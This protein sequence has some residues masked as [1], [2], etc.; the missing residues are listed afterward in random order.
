MPSIYLWRRLRSYYFDLYYAELDGEPSFPPF[1][2]DLKLTLAQRRR[3]AKSLD[4]AMIAVI[5]SDEEARANSCL[6]HEEL[7]GTQD[8][9]VDT[10]KKISKSLTTLLTIESQESD[11]VEEDSRLQIMDN[12]NLTPAEKTMRIL[13]ITR[14][15]IEHKKTSTTD[16]T[17]SNADISESSIDVDQKFSFISVTKESIGPRTVATQV[18]FPAGLKNDAEQHSGKCVCCEE[19]KCSVDNDEDSDEED[20]KPMSTAIVKS[21]TI[22][23]DKKGNN[24]DA[25]SSRKEKPSNCCNEN[26]KTNGEKKNAEGISLKDKIAPSG[27][28]TSFAYR[29]TDL[30]PVPCLQA[31]IERDGIAWDH[32]K[33]INFVS[34]IDK[35]LSDELKFFKLE[36]NYLDSQKSDGRPTSVSKNPFEDTNVEVGSSDKVTA[37]TLSQDKKKFRCESSQ[38]TRKILPERENGTQSNF[39]PLQFSLIEKKGFSLPTSASFGAGSEMLT[40]NASCVFDE[41]P[42]SGIQ[43]IDSMTV[44]TNSLVRLDQDVNSDSF[45]Q[46]SFQQ[47][48]NMFNDLRA[49]SDRFQYG[50]HSTSFGTARA[51]DDYS[52]FYEMDKLSGTQNYAMTRTRPYDS[53]QLSRSRIVTAESEITTFDF[54][55][56]RSTSQT[57]NFR[58]GHRDNWDFGQEVSAENEINCNHSTYGS[59]KSRDLS[60]APRDFYDHEKKRIISNSK[61]QVSSLTFN[62]S[63][64][65]PTRVSNQQTFPSQSGTAMNDTILN[66]EKF[67]KTSQTSN[68]GSVGFCSNLDPERSVIIEKSTITSVP[69][70]KLPSKECDRKDYKDRRSWASSS[71]SLRS[72]KSKTSSEKWEDRSL[73]ALKAYNEKT[74]YKYKRDMDARKSRDVTNVPSLLSRREENELLDRWT[75]SRLSSQESGPSCF[76]H[77]DLDPLSLSASIY[78]SNVNQALYVPSAP[79]LETPEKELIFNIENAYARFA[80]SKPAGPVASAAFHQSAAVKEFFDLYSGGGRLT[81]DSQRLRVGDEMKTRKQHSKYSKF[82]RETNESD[83]TSRSCKRIEGSQKGRD[84]ERTLAMENITRQEFEVYFLERQA[85]ER[86][87]SSKNV[88]ITTIKSFSRKRGDDDA[89]V[90]SSETLTPDDSTSPMIEVLENSEDIPCRID[91]N[92]FYREMR[93]KKKNNLPDNVR[94]VMENIDWSFRRMYC[95][96]SRSPQH[97]G[98]SEITLSTDHRLEH[99]NIVHKTTENL[100]QGAF[101]NSDNS[102]RGFRLGELG[103]EYYPIFNDAAIAMGEIVRAAGLRGYRDEFTSQPATEIE[104]PEID[105]GNFYGALDL[106]VKLPRSLSSRFSRCGALDEKTKASNSKQLGSMVVNPQNKIA[107]TGGRE[108]FI[109]QEE[110][111]TLLRRLIAPLDPRSTTVPEQLTEP[112][113]TREEEEDPSGDLPSRENSDLEDYSKF[114]FKS[115]PT[116]KRSPIS[117]RCQNPERSLH[118]GQKTKRSCER[119]KIALR[120]VI[121]Q[122]SSS[123]QGLKELDLASCRRI[124]DHFSTGG[125]EMRSAIVKVLEKFPHCETFVRTGDSSSLL[126]VILDERL[127]RSLGGS[128]FIAGLEMLSVLNLMTTTPSKIVNPDENSGGAEETPS[129][130]IEY[131]SREQNDRCEGKSVPERTISQS[132]TSRVIDSVFVKAM[133]ESQSSRTEVKKFGYKSSDTMESKKFSAMN[134]EDSNTLE[135][136]NSM[137]AELEMNAHPIGHESFMDAG[138]ITPDLLLGDIE[139]AESLIKKMKSVFERFVAEDKKS[140]DRVPKEEEEA[141]EEKTEISS[142]TNFDFLL[143]GE[144]KKLHRLVEVIANY[145]TV[146]EYSL[147][148]VSS[149]ETTDSPSAIKSSY[150]V[151]SFDVQRRELITGCEREKPDSFQNAAKDREKSNRDD[152]Q[153][154]QTPLSKPGSS[155]STENPMDRI[156]SWDEMIP[157]STKRELAK[158]RQKS[159]ATKRVVAVS[160]P[161]RRIV[162]V[163]KLVN[164]NDSD[165]FSARFVPQ[166]GRGLSSGYLMDSDSDGNFTISRPPTPAS[167]KSETSQTLYFDRNEESDVPSKHSAKTSEVIA[168]SETER[169][170]RCSLPNVP[171]KETSPS[172]SSPN[173][174]NNFKNSESEL[175]IAKDKID[176]DVKSLENSQRSLEKSSE[177]SLDYDDDKQLHVLSAEILLTDNALKNISPIDAIRIV[178]ELTTE[179]QQILFNQF[180]GV[181]CLTDGLPAA[182]KNGNSIT[183]SDNAKIDSLTNIQGTSYCDSVEDVNDLNRMKESCEQNVEGIM[184]VFFEELIAQ[185]K[186][187]DRISENSEDTLLEQLQRKS[188]VSLKHVATGTEFTAEVLRDLLETFSTMHSIGNNMIPVYGNTNDIDDKKRR[189]PSAER[190][191]NPESSPSDPDGIQV[192]RVSSSPRRDSPSSTSLRKNL[193]AEVDFSQ[194]VEFRN[195]KTID[196]NF[197][198]KEGNTDI[199]GEL[200]S[201]SETSRNEQSHENVVKKFDPLM[202]SFASYDSFASLLSQK[203]NEASKKSSRE[204]SLSDHTFLEEFPDGVNR[205]IESSLNLDKVL[206]KRSSDLLQSNSQ[207]GAEET[208]SEERSNKK[209]SSVNSA[210]SISSG[211]NGENKKRDGATEKRDT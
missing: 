126:E 1:K 119:V 84:L 100:L 172:T 30:C 155:R 35:V 178:N 50:G 140:K 149:N 136:R 124:L 66:A 194:S 165:F 13:G 85:D 21:R 22:S 96:E 128:E 189:I 152:D 80:R 188:I 177:V 169:L 106:P 6:T 42:V 133:R 98:P 91:D 199:S 179:V 162:K 2:P 33:E 121:H 68:H 193:I 86:P 120:D 197:L 147:D 192:I 51:I 173:L 168:A 94:E 154:A 39:E 5:S 186:D 20:N 114:L 93:K 92:E 198:V 208:G 159:K 24:D 101:A 145:A 70:E 144:I 108:T 44:P 58:S 16:V 113:E 41:T 150:E 210:T 166:R 48:S 90:V 129:S 31:I 18:R 148:V 49:E 97:A 107:E 43:S 72:S 116:P 205:S 38:G 123:V 8:W 160:E 28:T 53:S 184:K 211:S 25:D 125:K 99:Q 195:E 7:F 11:E 156:S 183:L 83:I 87:S 163:I 34:V 167:V 40:L 79:E 201:I 45:F 111:F 151:N 109:D 134:N 185:C 63:S 138:N 102:E 29:Q 182:P 110:V 204:I 17:E 170:S 122:S 139:T 26:R 32:L 206:D 164:E 207:N 103:N 37:G 3:A 69:R 105:C 181:R 115:S 112:A 60:F 65:H 158:S 64:I 95:T 175:Q 135:S 146:T 153:A 143:H 78:G 15:N 202:P 23:T 62:S 14:E 54:G 141:D 77:S 118:V 10:D 130:R 180:R 75:G 12:V 137:E 89:S 88:P 73:Q 19:T 52:R 187:G 117:S 174:K 191:H 161:Y 71:K 61:L 67:V 46:S 47:H 200:N 56:N 142:L 176:Y 157:L 36:R 82:S 9:H 59:E 209:S 132:G 27:V 55:C 196:E 104:I 4:G 74:L 57:P 190:S 203:R 81:R 76:D 127:P 171:I 131:S